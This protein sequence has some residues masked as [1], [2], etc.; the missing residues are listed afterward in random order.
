MGKETARPS[1]LTFVLAV[2]GRRDGADERLEELDAVDARA[3]RRRQVGAAP[4]AGKGNALALGDLAIAVAV[5][6]VAGQHLE[7]EAQRWY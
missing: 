1:P 4:L 6:L 7:E 5:L 2:D 3:R